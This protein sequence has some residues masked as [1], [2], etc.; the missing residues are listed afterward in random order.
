VDCVDHVDH[1]DVVD[2]VDPTAWGVVNITNLLSGI[3]WDGQ[4]LGYCNWFFAAV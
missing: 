3:S 1:V 2:V 4:T